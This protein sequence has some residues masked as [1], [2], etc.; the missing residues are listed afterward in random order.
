MLNQWIPV[1]HRQITEIFKK[2][3]SAQLIF[4]P[5]PS[6]SRP[7]SSFRLHVYRHTFIRSSSGPSTVHLQMHIDCSFTLCN[8]NYVFLRLVLHLIME[9]IYLF[10]IIYLFQRSYRVIEII[11]NRNDQIPNADNVDISYNRLMKFRSKIFRRKC[12]YSSV[13]ERKYKKN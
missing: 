6:I 11:R 4:H 7:V 12:F 9:N 3:M 2:L 13:N 1:S 5:T 8:T 10:Q